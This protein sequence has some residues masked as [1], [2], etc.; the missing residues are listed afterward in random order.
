M[1][2]YEDLQQANIHEIGRP[3]CLSLLGLARVGRIVFCDD[4]GPLALPVNF[5]MHGERVLFRV[6]PGGSLAR[7]LDGATVAF[8]VDR[9]DG[10]QQL[11]WSVLVRGE[12]S[13]VDN[14]EDL[15][16]QLSALP[17]P[18]ARGFRPV[19]VQVRPTRITGRRLLDD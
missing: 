1:T 15:P 14:E 17:V 18:W 10:F 8:E 5:R 19:Y 4:E 3:E 13:F 7:R 16:E 11:G 6:P 2:T 12:A 9:I